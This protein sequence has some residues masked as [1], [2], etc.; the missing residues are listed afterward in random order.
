M[1]GALLT[2]YVPP[3]ALALGFPRSGG[4]QTA[5]TA[6][7]SLARWCYGLLLAAQSPVIF[8]CQR[9]WPRWAMAGIATVLF[10]IG[11]AFADFCFSQPALEHNPVTAKKSRRAH[12]RRCFFGFLRLTICGQCA[13]HGSVAAGARHF[14]STFR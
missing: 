2:G 10:L 1:A 14:S 4:W 7:N 9:G 3:I 13:A 5:G 11:L 8:H 6:R 12:F